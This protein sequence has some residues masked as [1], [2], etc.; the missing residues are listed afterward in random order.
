MAVTTTLP[1]PEETLGGRIR[2]ARTY[3]RLKQGE[4]AD[5]VP[6]SRETISAWEN[7][8]TAPTVPEL[9]RIAGATSFPARFFVDGL[10]STGAGAASRAGCPYVLDP[11]Q[12]SLFDE[13]VP[14][15]AGRIAIPAVDLDALTD[16][17]VPVVLG[18]AA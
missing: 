11:L 4:L 9:L 17:L 5:A 7:N 1:A 8:R 18:E 13:L 10:P 3:S 6:V 16:R 2:Q 12:P 15:R 14:I